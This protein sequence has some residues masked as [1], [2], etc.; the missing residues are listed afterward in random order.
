MAHLPRGRKIT[1]SEMRKSRK[2]CGV[3]TTHLMEMMQESFIAHRSAKNGLVLS[4]VVC[5]S[6]ACP[7]PPPPPAMPSMEVQIEATFV[8]PYYGAP[9]RS[10]ICAYALRAVKASGAKM[11]CR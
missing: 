6:D 3:E 9:S 2:R 8:Y 5:F 10:N 4:A 1:K 7:L 11:C